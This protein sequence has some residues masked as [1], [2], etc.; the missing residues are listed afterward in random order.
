MKAVSTFG[1]S[2][3]IHPESVEK[4]LDSIEE[5]GFQPDAVQK[6][7]D[8]LDRRAIA[9]SNTAALLRGAFNDLIDQNN[10]LSTQIE[11]K[12]E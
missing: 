11:E 6:A 8:D 9:G 5:K 7:L 10:T 3:V 4:R 12:G 1:L 2:E